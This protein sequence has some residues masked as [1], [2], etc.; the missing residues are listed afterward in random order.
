MVNGP[1]LS[2]CHLGN[3]FS[4]PDDCASLTLFQFQSGLAH[5]AAGGLGLFLLRLVKFTQSKY[6]SWLLF[7][8]N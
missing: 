2:A 6:V 8:M 4:D 5:N 1:V 3:K 7:H